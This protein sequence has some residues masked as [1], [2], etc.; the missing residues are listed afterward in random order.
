MRRKWIALAL[1]VCLAAAA[2]A[3]ASAFFFP[4]FSKPRMIFVIK[5][6]MTQRM[7]RIA[8]VMPM[9]IRA[10]M[11]VPAIFSP[12]ERLLKYSGCANC[13]I[14]LMLCHLP[15]GEC[16]RASWPAG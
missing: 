9:P 12:K 11:P 10:V 14:K 3:G 8:K 2:A 7:I 15:K 6:I 5:A 13:S 16:C 4:A 1:A